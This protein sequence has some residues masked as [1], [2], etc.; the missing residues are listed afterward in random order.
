VENGSDYDG[1]NAKSGKHEAQD[2]PLTGSIALSLVGVF[3]F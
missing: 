2:I 3:A 1:N